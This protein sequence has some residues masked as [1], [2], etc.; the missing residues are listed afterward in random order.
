MHFSVRG[1]LFIVLTALLGIAGTWSDDPAFSGAWLFPAFLLLG[2]LAIE[3]W[4][5]RGTRVSGFGR[6][7]VVAGNARENFDQ[8]APKISTSSCW[9][10]AIHSPTSPRWQSCYPNAFAATWRS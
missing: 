7:E 2:G 4:Y 8:A 3:A 6:F 1:Y 5:Q 9:R 10:G